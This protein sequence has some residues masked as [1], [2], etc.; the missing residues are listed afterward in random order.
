MNPN[1]LVGLGACIVG[2]GVAAWYVL[3]E[4]Y[5]SSMK[6]VKELCDAADFEEYSEIHKFCHDFEDMPLDQEIECDTEGDEDSPQDSSNP[7]FTLRELFE[8]DD[9]ETGFNTIKER[10]SGGEAGGD[11]KLLWF[12]YGWCSTNM[13][14]WKLYGNGDKANYCNPAQ[15]SHGGRCSKFS[16]AGC[17]TTSRENKMRQC[18][19]D[20]DHCLTVGRNDDGTQK[21]YKAGPHTFKEVYGDQEWNPGMRDT[22][23][24]VNSIGKCPSASR[25]KNQCRGD[26]DKAGGECGW[27]VS[28]RY[29]SWWWPKWDWRCSVAST[30]VAALYPKSW[31]GKK[32]N[33]LTCA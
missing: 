2:L 6:T 24:G 3:S 27:Q 29:G 23:Y 32:W 22:V 19:I 8:A 26:C 14:D 15:D 4:S 17:G 13:L 18:C 11:R 25:F 30:A 21:L 9:I 12:Y 31:T 5:D 33:G 10:C 20:H 1:L 7:T 16:V 28:C